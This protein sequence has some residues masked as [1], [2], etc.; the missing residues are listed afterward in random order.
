MQGIVLLGFH[1]ILCF[2]DTEPLT[3]NLIYKYS[4]EIEDNGGGMVMSRL[5]MLSYLLL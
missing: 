2:K 5:S 4:W 1:D 3:S